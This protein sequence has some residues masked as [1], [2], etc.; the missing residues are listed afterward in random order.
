MFLVT[1]T[2][3]SEFGEVECVN[4]LGVFSTKELA[5]RRISID[6]EEFVKERIKARP[7]LDTPLF[8]DLEDFAFG[9][10]YA[11]DIERAKSVDDRDDE[12]DENDEN[13]NPRWEYAV[14]VL[15]LDEGAELVLANRA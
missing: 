14:R 13:E 7:E 2:E 5:K 10:G 4:T 6:I 11:L 9:G 3:M 1:K 8:R 15:N 12:D